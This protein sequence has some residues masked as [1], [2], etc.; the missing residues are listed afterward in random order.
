M[1]IKTYLSVALAVAL[2]FLPHVNN[3]IIFIPAVLIST[4]IP[5]IENPNFFKKGFKIFTTTKEDLPKNG[6]LHTYTFC[7]MVSLIFAF[8]YPVLALPFF[9]GYSFHLLLDTFTPQGIRPFWPLKQRTSGK[10]APGG[11]IEKTI[12]YIFIIFDIALLLKLFF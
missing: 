7:I 1:H 12:F 5:E 8:F 2:Y 10:V 6:I 4:L 11:K 3:K 9:L